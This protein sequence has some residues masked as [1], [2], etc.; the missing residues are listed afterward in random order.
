MA[1]TT[2]STVPTTVARMLIKEIGTRTASRALPH[3][4]EHEDQREECACQPSER[5]HLR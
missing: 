4:V 3:H 5:R 1:T 2:P